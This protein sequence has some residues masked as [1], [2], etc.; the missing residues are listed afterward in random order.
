MYIH[1]NSISMFNSML[2]VLAKFVYLKLK[3]RLEVEIDFDYYG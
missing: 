3:L 2:D 1:L